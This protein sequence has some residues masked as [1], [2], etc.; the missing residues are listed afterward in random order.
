MHLK[1]FRT[2]LALHPMKKLDLSN[3][4]QIFAIWKPLGI[5]THVL[6]KRVAQIMEVPVAHTG[7]LDPMAEG[8]V[9]LLS[10]EERFKKRELA[11]WQKVYEFEITFGLATDTYDLMGFIGQT[12]FD[13][14]FNEKTLNQ[15]IEN[16]PKTYQQAYP[17][18]SAKK[19]KGKPLHYHAQMGTLHTIEVPTLLANI[20]ELEKISVGKVTAK[21]LYDHATSKIKKV[22]GVFR[23]E[24]ILKNWD[25]FL[26]QTPQGTIFYTAT[27]QAVVS[28][29]VYVRTLAV[30]IAQKL[31]TVALVSNLI[32]T[33]N[34][35]FSKDSCVEY[36]QILAHLQTTK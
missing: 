17:P 5:S 9:V 18:F 28:R 29:G 4:N 19:I 8:V 33:K 31:N 21:Q 12:A 10:G 30:D 16:F 14:I 20:Y 15:T 6:S 25:Q 35:D 26:A 24:E 2:I 23:Q 7:T 36:E 32:R 11:G 27:L 22:E 3:K 1:F 13:F 34:G